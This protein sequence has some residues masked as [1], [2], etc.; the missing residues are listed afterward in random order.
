[1]EAGGQGGL[2]HKQ[3]KSIFLTKMEFTVHYT[4]QMPALFTNISIKIHKFVNQ[5]TEG[6]DYFLLLI[7][8]L[9]YRETHFQNY[10][11]FF[12]TLKCAAN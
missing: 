4:R 2:A 9:V 12:Y 11:I 8:N 10:H 1:M 7:I 5:K 3:T 6:Q